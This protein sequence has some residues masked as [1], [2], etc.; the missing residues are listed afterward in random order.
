M[1]VCSRHD[2][3]VSRSVPHHVTSQLGHHMVAFRRA[4]GAKIRERATAAISPT[5]GARSAGIVDIRDVTLDCQIVQPETGT[6]GREVP[7]QRG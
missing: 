6:T 1:A 3:Q 2:Q 7:R 4:F 5:L